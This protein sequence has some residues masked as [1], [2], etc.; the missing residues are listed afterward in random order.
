MVLILQ[1]SIIIKHYEQD[2]SFLCSSTLNHA[3]CYFFCGLKLTVSLPSLALWQQASPACETEPVLNT[4]AVGMWRVTSRDNHQSLIGFCSLLTLLY[5][6]WK[7]ASN[8]IW[9][10]TII[11]CSY[12]LQ[13]TCRRLSV[14]NTLVAPLPLHKT[15]VIVSRVQ[16]QLYLYRLTWCQ[17]Y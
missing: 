1:T 10:R 3:M 11:S 6:R 16:R 9:T 13:E 5:C 12:L 4:Q 15:P 17:C 7:S 8:L 2:I 14:T